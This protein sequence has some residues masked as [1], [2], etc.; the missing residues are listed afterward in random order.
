MKT[1]NSRR[2]FLKVGATLS[3]A[4][5]IPSSI[6]AENLNTQVVKNGTVI[7]AA[8]WGILKATVEN[9][10]IPTDMANKVDTVF[11]E[12]ETKY[13]ADLGLTSTMAIHMLSLEIENGTIGIDYKLSTAGELVLVLKCESVLRED[14]LVRYTMGYEIEFKY[15]P[16]DNSVPQEEY[17]YDEF[18]DWIKE[19]KEVVMGFLTLDPHCGGQQQKTW[20]R[21]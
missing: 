13:T 21:S 3:L 9:G 17:A 16:K 20:V 12:L 6:F 8:H 2:N 4:P 15:L 14:V 10:K 5:L 19:N 1:N 18:F 11:G 7:T